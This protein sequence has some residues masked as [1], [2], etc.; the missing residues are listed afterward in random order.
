MNWSKLGNGVWWAA[1]T[2][3]APDPGP[4]YTNQAVWYAW[5]S[6]ARNENIQ[7]V[8]FNVDATC[9][10]NRF[11]IAQNG[12]YTS[13]TFT[14]GTL[15]YLTADTFTVGTAV[16][17]ASGAQFAAG[18]YIITEESATA[19]SISNAALDP[20]PGTVTVPD[21]YKLIKIDSFGNI[22]QITQ[23]NTLE[24][25]NQ[26]LGYR[27]GY[28][29]N[30]FNYRTTSPAT[31]EN[32]VC[33]I[34]SWIATLGNYVN[35][36]NN[37]AGAG[38]K[39]LAGTS[40]EVGTTLYQFDG[41]NYYQSGT[42]ITTVIS[43]IAGN[44][45]SQIRFLDPNRPLDLTPDSYQI[46][47][48]GANGVIS[49]IDQYNTVACSVEVCSIDWTR[50]N[51]SST[52]LKTGGNIPILNTS[53]A[54]KT[55]YDNQ[56]PA[57]CHVDFD[58]NNASYGLLY[59]YFAKDTIQPPTGYRLPTAADYTALSTGAC[60]TG[61]NYN[62]YGANPGNWDTTLLTNTTELGDTD[63]N[64]QGYGY[65][66]LI[67]NSQ[68]FARFSEGE[69]YWDDG[70]S[71]TLGFDISNANGYLVT[72]SLSAGTNTQ[73]SHFIRFVKI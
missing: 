67:N 36:G 32:L 3:P 37:A 59:N 44:S 12:D 50:I 47:I 18:H 15:K 73:R 7:N 53:A 62:R 42:Y 22:A 29:A 21:T 52:K 43:P 58:V 70:T 4:A 49:S 68:T 72:S 54:W 24:C 2:T 48:V 17:T 33:E 14:G 61:Q 27:I 55:A 64:I 31:S 20:D 41:V 28:N 30:L 60:F 10:L 16:L 66:R 40:F 1:N 13:V 57:A 69:W 65:A 63:L 71:T 9:R 6:N 46:V 8:T 11:Y 5:N 23:Y 56:T 51:S 19:P 38:A 45:P 35:T 26:N 25:Q 39:F 34:N